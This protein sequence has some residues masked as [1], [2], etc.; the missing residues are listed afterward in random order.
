MTFHCGKPFHRTFAKN[1]NP[2]TGEAEETYDARRT[3]EMIH[4]IQKKLEHPDRCLAIDWDE[5]DFGIL[6]NLA[7][8]HFASPDTQNSAEEAGLRVM[9]RTS[10]G[11]DR[12]PEKVR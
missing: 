9:H 6:D 12:R 2:K 4:T 11:G 3:A 8:A 10:V 5:G 7:M 1:Y